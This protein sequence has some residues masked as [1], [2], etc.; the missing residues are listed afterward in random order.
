MPNDTELTLTEVTLSSRAGALQSGY[1]ISSEHKDGTTFTL[2]RLHR[3][4]AA[5]DAPTLVLK[6]YYNQRIKL[7]EL[8]LEVRCKAL[9]GGA[10]IEVRSSEPT[11]AI[12]PQQV[13]EN[14]VIAAVG[15]TVNGVSMD[16]ELHIQPGSLDQLSEDA[17]ISLEL[18]KI[19]SPK[20]P[21]R[22][23]ILQKIQINFPR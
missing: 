9:V 20:A 12:A 10:L 11:F 6:A 2:V 16:L 4:S 13:E 22:K 7:E 14:R 3:E 5:E 18:S 23:T 17:S 8:N 19:E 21:V 15:T 1:H